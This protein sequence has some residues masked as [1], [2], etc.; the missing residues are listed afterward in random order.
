MHEGSTRLY[1][2]AMT[3][4][5]SFIKLHLLDLRVATCRHGH[6]SISQTEHAVFRSVI[7][8]LGA[9]RGADGPLLDPK[10]IL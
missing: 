9:Y 6:H 4:H 8:S 3:G 2:Y 5:C 10:R 1:L 7:G